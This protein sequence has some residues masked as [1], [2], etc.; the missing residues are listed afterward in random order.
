MNLLKYLII[1]SIISLLAFIYPGVALARIVPAGFSK[2]QL[3][4]SKDP[5]FVGDNITISTLVYNSSNY[6]MQGVMN[7]KN[8]TT[9][10]DKRSFIIEGGGNSQVIAFPWVVTSGTHYFEVHIENSEFTQ[11]T[12]TLASSTVAAVDTA[13]VKRFADY[14]KNYNGVGDSTE[15]IIDPV[16]VS[17]KSTS[18]LQLP[19]NP[20]NTVKQEIE[21]TAPTP[22][23]SIALPVIGTIE[24][25]RQGQAAKAEH[26]IKNIEEIISSHA[27][28]TS[29]DGNRE[30]KSHG[31]T[32]IF[33]GLSNGQV[34][35]SPIEYLQ[36][37]LALVLHSLV[38]NP[39]VFYILLLILLYKLSRITIGLF[40]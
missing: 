24:S 30:M 10:L 5:F 36:L 27:V 15:P 1:L 11:G 40:T 18:S 29:T 33:D 9:T 26:R 12:N 32:T 25:L 22:V 3:W 20:V 8:G 37:L 38:G 21:D 19:A 2:D 7:L 23:S 28:A 4:F 13:K 14:D 39:Y 16:P 35:R 31:W 6:R 17:I 34:V